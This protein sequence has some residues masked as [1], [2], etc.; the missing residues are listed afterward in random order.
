ML[1][2]VR[3]SRRLKLARLQ[4]LEVIKA[5]NEHTVEAQEYAKEHGEEILDTTPIFE[6]DEYDKESVKKAFFELTK[7]IP[8]WR[9]RNGIWYPLNSDSELMFEIG[10]DECEWL[11]TLDKQ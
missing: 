3:N 5:V 8:F 4:M 9:T 1:E 2:R 10:S 7:Y 11:D 6:C